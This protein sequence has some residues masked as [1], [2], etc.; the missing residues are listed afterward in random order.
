MVLS[1]H[2]PEHFSY[3]SPDDPYFKRVVLRMIERMTGQPYLKHLYETNRHSLLPGEN[4]WEAAIRLLE[5]DI[6]HN[7]EALFAVPREG[8]LVVVANHPFGVLD[9]IVISYLTSKIRPEFRVLTNSVLYR[10][11]EIR[12]FLIPV[13]FAETKEA[14]EAN[15]RARAAARTF[16]REGGCVV[17]FPAG[18]ASTTP[19]PWSKKA[20]DLEWKTF[21]AG[22]IL[23][24]KSPVLPIY[25]AG[26]NSRLF[27][28]ASHISMTLRLSLFFKEVYD[29]IGSKISVRVGKTI[30]FL[31]LEGMDRKKFMQHLRDVTY[32]MAPLTPEPP[33][34]R[35]ARREKRVPR[36]R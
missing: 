31:E 29:K 5:L 19:T 18:G 28:V 27:Q 30:P 34:T 17:V 32:A 25:F 9:G 13:D 6:V 12:P 22:M 23:Q 4:F 3:A 8:P 15:I 14:M 2:E 11:E 7:E 35:K 26:Q 10:A 1:A 16:L 21:T 36:S 33:R 20:T 24:T